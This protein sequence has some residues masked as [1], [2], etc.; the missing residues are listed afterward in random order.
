MSRDDKESRFDQ[1]FAFDFTD[2][3]YVDTSDDEIVKIRFDEQT[4]GIVHGGEPTGY[5]IT[6][7]WN[8]RHFTIGF[9]KNSILY[10]ITREDVDDR[11]SGKRSMTRSEYV[12]ELYGFVRWMA[13][14]TPKSR[15]PFDMVGTLDFE[16]ARH[17]LTQKQVVE[18]ADD[19]LSV[20]F[21]QQE[22]LIKELIDNPGKV[23]ELLGKILDPI[24][25]DSLQSSGE[26][27][28]FR[29]TATRLDIIFLYP[30]EYVGVVGASELFRALQGGG[31]SQIIDHVIR[32]ITTE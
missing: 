12:A 10:H 11:R 22:A 28:F 6:N 26:I 13:P 4:L 20:D 21:D 9:G 23:G 7:D 29:P 2:G 14:P 18:Y 24:S 17:Y 27:V 25:F 5:S 8:N 31:G 19:G 16:A 1:I 32:S 15:V 30:G 3:I